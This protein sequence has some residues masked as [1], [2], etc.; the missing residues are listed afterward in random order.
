MTGQMLLMPGW[1]GTT[2]SR[3]VIG[4]TSSPGDVFLSHASVSTSISVDARAIEQARRVLDGGIRDRLAE[5]REAASRRALAMPMYE[6]PA[7]EVA[8]RARLVEA[9][10]EL[11]IETN[12]WQAED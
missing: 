7:D 5:L 8:E 4:A 11:Q 6:D 12:A 1:G 10:E 9:F 3:I 2:S